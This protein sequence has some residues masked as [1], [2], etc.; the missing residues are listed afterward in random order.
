MKQAQRVKQSEVEGQIV[1][2]NTKH[3]A[4]WLRAQFAKLYG[5]EIINTDKDV[6]DSTGWNKTNIS[7]YLNPDSG[8]RPSR[9]FVAKFIEIYGKYLEDDVSLAEEVKVLKKRVKE[10]EAALRDKEKI[11]KLAGL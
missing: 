6:S 10:L 11:I 2:M 1:P 5:K 3:D 8:I 9:F 4:V 7:N